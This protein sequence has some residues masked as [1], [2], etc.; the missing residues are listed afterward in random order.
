MAGKAGQKAR[1]MVGH[2]REQRRKSR[3]APAH[4]LKC[5]ATMAGNES[6]GAC[7]YLGPKGELTAKS[8]CFSLST[9]T[10]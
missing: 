4:A 1:A 7:G 8:M 9:R 2:T 5:T 10:R 6:N 3:A